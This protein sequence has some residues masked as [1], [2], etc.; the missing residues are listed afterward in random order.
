MSITFLDRYRNESNWANKVHIIEIFHLTHQHHNKGWT[1]TFTAN[2]FGVSIA[3]VSENLKIARYSHTD[4]SI[5]KCE[6]REEALAKV[7]H[8]R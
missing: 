8:A 2:Y 3:L 4:E 7:N 1:I 6:T 5:L